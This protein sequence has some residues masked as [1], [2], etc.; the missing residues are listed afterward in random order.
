[1]KNRKL[2]EKLQEDGAAVEFPSPNRWQFAEYSRELRDVVLENVNLVLRAAAS[3][4]DSW[5]WNADMQAFTFDVV[6][7]LLVETGCWKDSA[8]PVGAFQRMACTASFGINPHAS[9]VEEIKRAS[10]DIVAWHDALFELRKLQIRFVKE[11]HGVD[12]F[13]V[14]AERR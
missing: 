2:L 3:V 5:A 9:L 14:A 10:R 12:A 8:L 7:E 1:M 13:M 6:D 4:R 11:A